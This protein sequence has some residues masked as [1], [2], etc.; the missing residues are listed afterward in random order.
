M[1]GE[2]GTVEVEI[3]VAFESLRALSEGFRDLR[4]G[5]S[6]RVSFPGGGGIFG[7]GR[8]YGGGERV[9]ARDFKGGE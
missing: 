1:S 7:R 2:R 5:Q 4:R 9:G 6:L 8:G 3:A